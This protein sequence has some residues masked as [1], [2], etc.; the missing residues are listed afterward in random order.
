MGLLTFARQ[1]ALD[2]AHLKMQKEQQELAASQFD[3]TLD[4]HN[5]QLSQQQANSEAAPLQQLMIHNPESAGDIGPAVSAIHSY[6]RDPS[7]VRAFNPGASSDPETADPNISAEA[8]API[9]GRAAVDKYISDAYSATGRTAQL[10]KDRAY[11]SQEAL[12]QSQEQRMKEQ[13]DLAREQIKQTGDLRRTM[14]QNQS[15]YRSPEYLEEASKARSRG[16]ASGAGSSS[17]VGSIADAIENGSQPPDTKGLYRFGAPVRAELARRGFDVSAA[18]AEWSAYQKHLA[19]ANGPQQTRLAQA[20]KTAN[21]SLDNI[22]GLYQEWKQLGGASGY[23]ALNKVELAASKQVPG[24]MGE[25]ARALEMN[26][27]DLTSELG[28]AY[29]G[30]NSPTDH[31]LTLAKQNLSADWNEGQFTEAIKQARKNIGY[32][33]NAMKLV[34]PAGTGENRYAPGEPGD[35]SA[36]P[37]GDPD[38]LNHVAGTAAQ[39]ASTRQGPP[40][41]T[42]DADYDALPPGAQ[43]VAPDGSLRRKGKK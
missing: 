23:Q 22:E 35:S 6:L 26:I 13:S 34:G 17:D 7:T 9:T 39:K 5:R 32:R 15:F 42:S 33:L 24:R 1:T 3:R 10:L 30:G 11:E 4:L 14:L 12:R 37:A 28:N 27:A 8:A 40:K 20:L 25:V 21:E 29:M 18:S 19:T 43:Y 31:A 41:V 36:G 16:S 38:V 2:L